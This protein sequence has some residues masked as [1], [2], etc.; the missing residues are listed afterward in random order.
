MALRVE[1]DPRAEHEARAAF[2]WY[3]ERSER[4]AI[5]FQREIDQAIERIGEA[6]TTYPVIDG[7]LRRYLSRR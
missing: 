3:L 5:A 1:L 4:A 7:E 6:P 2:R